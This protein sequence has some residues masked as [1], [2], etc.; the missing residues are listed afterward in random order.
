MAEYDLAFGKKLA[1][2]AADLAGHGLYTLD[3]QRTVLYLGLL[4]VEISI[5]ALLERA[6]VA[7]PAIRARSHRLE[8][9]LNDLDSCEVGVEISPGKTKRVSASR[10]R[11][12]VVEHGGK[13]GT[14]GQILAA[15]RAGASKY[16]NNIRYGDILTHYPAG[17]VSAMASVVYKF[18]EKNWDN[19][20]LLQFHRVPTDETHDSLPNVRAAMHELCAALGYGYH[21]REREDESE[22]EKTIVR[23]PIYRLDGE[24]RGV[25]H[26][27]LDKS[28]FITTAYA[29][30]Y[31]DGKTLGTASA[32]DPQKFATKFGPDVDLLKV[33]LLEAIER[34]HQR[35]APKA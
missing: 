35:V 8:D 3:A 32:N 15:E 13:E 1:E 20:K 26:G 24:S 12:L 7:V 14:V 21:V 34:A 5:K 22:G 16:P 18:A 11:S 30:V 4:S 25:A 19:I 10:I 23:Y 9:L 31:M 6:G 29:V 27:E 33:V 17:V 28:D 2:T